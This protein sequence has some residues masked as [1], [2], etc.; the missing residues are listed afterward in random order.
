MTTFTS[1][2]HLVRFSAHV[3][4]ALLA[5]YP[6]R[7]RQEYG[8]HMAQVFRDACLHA[9]RRS[10]PPGMLS[11][12][13]LTLFDWVKSVIEEQFNRAT[14]M[15]RAKWIR[16]SGWAMMAGAVAMQLGFLIDSNQIRVSMYHL[17]GPP[18]TR[19]EYDQYVTIANQLQGIPATLGILLLVL[20][21]SGLRQRYG[22]QLH[23]KGRGG[24]AVCTAGGVL[25]VSGALGLPFSDAAW[26]VFATGLSLMFGSLAMFGVVAVR[27]GLLPKWSGLPLLTCFWFPF[28]LVVSL[29]YEWVTGGLWLELPY[30]VDWIFMTLAL[31]SLLRMGFELQRGHAGVVGSAAH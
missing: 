16:L 15:T 8:P 22:D 11:L 25:T 17:V 7:F 19:A 1:D 13:A 27:A 31:L 12:W 18:V 6:R 24:F 26:S 3:Y 5:G 4:S 14:E 10:G 30:A 28:F 23:A 2:P 9:Y 20:S 21:I 29:V